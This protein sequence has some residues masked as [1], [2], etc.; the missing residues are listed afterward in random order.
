MSMCYVDSL[1]GIISGSHSNSFLLFQTKKS[2]STI[3]S[4]TKIF[5]IW[6]VQLLPQGCGGSLAHPLLPFLFQ[7][8][9]QSNPCLLFFGSTFQCHPLLLLETLANFRL[10]RLLRTFVDLL[11]FSVQIQLQAGEISSLAMLLC[12]RHS[13]LKGLWRIPYILF[14]PGLYSK[15]AKRKPPS[16]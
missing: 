11:D 14:A 7:C 5:W 6:R 15:C 4:P 2:Y 10:H 1:L 12:H 16:S 3:F 13:V 8:W 9:S